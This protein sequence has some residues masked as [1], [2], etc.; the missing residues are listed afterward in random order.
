VVQTFGFGDYAEP[1]GCLADTGFPFEEESRRTA[2]ERGEEGLC[3]GQ[4]LT[5]TDD[6]LVHF[7]DERNPRASL[8]AL[9]HKVRKV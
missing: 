4:L 1:K 7:V 5:S 6:V 2:T 9:S 3:R 8:V